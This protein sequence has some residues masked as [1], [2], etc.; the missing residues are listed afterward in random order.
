MRNP[1]ALQPGDRRKAGQRD[2]NRSRSCY[3]PSMTT[4]EFTCAIAPRVFCGEHWLTL[5]VALQIGR[6]LFGGA[7]AA[8]SIRPHCH[9]HNTVQFASQRFAQASR[10][11]RTAACDVLD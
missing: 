8:L 10:A 5:E 9:Q 4:D 2:E 3:R 1:F 6:E 7:V 11:S